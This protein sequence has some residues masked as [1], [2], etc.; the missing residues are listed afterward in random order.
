[1]IKVEITNNNSHFEFPVDVYHL[2]DGE[3]KFPGVLDD[4]ELLEIAHYVEATYPSRWLKSLPEDFKLPIDHVF[5]EI[6]WDD[7]KLWRIA[8]KITT[9]AQRFIYEGK[10]VGPG[11][12]QDTKYI[13]RECVVNPEL[14][15]K[16]PKSYL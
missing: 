2:L 15:Y 11:I 7:K 14:S 10:D 12:S 3:Q 13:L 5:M 1:M 9:E 8:M 4:E 6:F 16:F